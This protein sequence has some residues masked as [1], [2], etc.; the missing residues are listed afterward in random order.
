MPKIKAFETHS[1]E[2]DEW[3]DKNAEL[4]QAELKLIKTMIGTLC[5]K[6]LEIGVGT[7]KFAVPL[8][9]KTGIEPCPQMVRKAKEQGV[10]VISSIAEHLPFKDKTFDFILMVTTVCF[11][12]DI[13]LS[14]KEARRVLKDKGHFIVAYVD[15]DSFL[16]KQY[17]L[18]KEKSKFYKEA[19][20][21]G[22]EEILYYLNSAGF[23]SYVIKQTILNADKIDLMKDGFGEGAF[24]AILSSK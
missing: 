19:T 13:L 23:K 5:E 16:G 4:Y 8:N 14:F 24:V 12:D 7:G 1:K 21:Y 22:T 17:E 15:K 3:F 6:S 2:Y 9:I 18:K 10:S 11:V 20:F